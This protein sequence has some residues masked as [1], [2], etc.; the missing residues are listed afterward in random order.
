MAMN[1]QR[2]DSYVVGKQLFDELVEPVAPDT[3]GFVE[4]SIMT[5]AQFRKNA[6]RLFR[7]FVVVPSK[8]NRKTHKLG[9]QQVIPIGKNGVCINEV[10]ADQKE[11]V[12]VDQ[13]IEYIRNFR[14]GADE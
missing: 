11:V 10:A 9:I 13:I 14:F 4:N 3:L 6:R 7:H 5:F 2:K 1:G 8:V 12:G